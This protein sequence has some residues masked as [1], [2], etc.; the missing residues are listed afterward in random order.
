MA[1]WYI[2]W[3]ILLLLGVVVSRV[4][5]DPP[6]PVVQKVNGNLI[7]GGNVD[8]FRISPDSE[9]ITYWADQ[10][11][12]N[13]FEIYS[14]PSRG[15]VP[16]KLNSAL[17]PGKNVTNFEISPGS[18]RVI[19]L[20]DQDIDEVFELYSVPIGGG[21]PVKLN[22]P[23]TLGKNVINFELMQGSGRVI[24]RADQ[25]TDEVYELYSAPIGGG[26]PVKLNGALVPGKN[27]EAFKIS[28]DNSRVVYRADQDTDNGFELYSVPIDGGTPIKLNG[29]IV[30][31]GDVY[32][33]LVSSDSNWVVYRADQDTNDGLELY[34]VPIGGGTPI[35]LNGSIAPGGD[36]GGTFQIS[37]DSRWVIY[38]ADQ[39]AKDLYEI[40]SVPIA[41]GPSIL[42]NGS[43]TSGG[44]V[45]AFK[46]SPDSRR[47]IY[48]A[49]QD[50][51]DGFEL[52][53]VPVGGG[54]VVKLNG[55]IV[56]GGDVYEFLV[57]SDSSWV[58]YRADQD[59]NDGFELYSVPIGGGTVVK[60]N[61][62]I[63]PGGDVGTF[64]I[65][66]D[67]NRVI[68]Q[69]DQDTNDLLELY[70]VPVSGGSPL[71]LNGLIAPGGDVDGNFELS[72]DSNFVVHRGDQATNDIF[73]L[74]ISYL[75]LSVDTTI[76]PANRIAVEPN[77]KV[78][79]VYSLPFDQSTVNNQTITVHGFQSGSQTGPVVIANDKTLQ[80]TVA[81]PFQPG[82]LVQVTARNTTQNNY[83]LSATPYVWQFYA[84]ARTGSGVF[85]S[86][87][88]ALGGT[89][90]EGVALGDVDGDSDPDAIVVYDHS[91]GGSPTGNEVYLNENGQFSRVQELGK[92]S[93]KAVALGDLNNDGVLDAFVVNGSNEADE[94]WLNT[95]NTSP[96]FQVEQLN[97]SFSG[98]D[99]ALA[100]FDGDGD[101]DAA[102]TN[103]NN[104]PNQIYINDGGTFNAKQALGSLSSLS[105]AVGDVDL[106][107]DIDALVG[108]AESP[109][110]LWLND[111]D[112]NFSLVQNIDTGNSAQAIALADFD[113]D[114]DL[115]AFFA[116][117]STLGQPNQFWVNSEG[118]FIN[119]ELNLG[120][121]NN[122]NSRELS[123]GDINADGDLD[124]FE[125]TLS[126]YVVWHNNG[127][128][129]F[130]SA[131][132]N[133]TSSRAVALADVD[134]DGDLDAYAGDYLD[135]P[136]T[137]LLNDLS[138]APP[139]Y[140]QAVFLPTIFRAPPI[141]ST[142]TQI[143]I[144]SI[145]TGGICRVE[146]TNKA[147]G[148][149]G[150][151]GGEI[152]DGEILADYKTTLC[153]Q[154]TLPP[155]DTTYRVKV[156]PKYCKSE[157][158]IFY[159]A[160]GVTRFREVECIER[161]SSAL[162]PK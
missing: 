103:T 113:G 161:S 93:S 75:P 152:N 129:N 12:N 50:T 58:V 65:R 120:I 22:V 45:D 98:T 122:L 95:G 87:A 8:G 117:G 67:S 133:T 66:P 21:T 141:I 73:E 157:V 23:L 83:G 52:Y 59:T 84:K 4:Y 101:L 100:D 109:V 156:F 13:I 30:P 96:I 79:I 91:T 155:Q 64:Q 124:I 90:S 127:T 82:E 48:W 99:V 41:G 7:G 144:V 9:W 159:D 86:T 6:E 132:I 140:E 160:V 137:I 29:P 97:D 81:D 68:Y 28:P 32:E 18:G 106:D 55:P 136:D 70:S 85:T 89:R 40:F 3:G 34:S 62:P 39:R 53:S 15:G 47:V 38:P 5:A 142:T 16:L 154:I 145:G 11:T 108:N 25:D 17:T 149:L 94:I 77:S 36:V 153:S 125:A 80:L 63:A 92:A 119:S 150:G 54:T 42:L 69:A 112:A 107:G 14:V 56:P 46:I 72:L 143:N 162:C 130:H 20:A 49:D 31:G 1:R 105:I 158:N 102:V 146:I 134:G 2:C 110:G 51:N 26:T 78:G 27:V 57:S 151:C 19:Y 131:Q 114:Y 138:M 35:R 74:F 123:I 126:G 88:Q 148:W 115:D 121:T 33:F 44:N 135:T 104:A 116:H 61:G 37:L 118:R 76:P 43:L 71:K 147:G 139:D 111:G 24:Y 10:D 128:G 60:L